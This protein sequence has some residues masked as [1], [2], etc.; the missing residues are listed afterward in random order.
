MRPVKPRHAALAA[1][2]A[3][4][5][6]HLVHISARSTPVTARIRSHAPGVNFLRSSQGEGKEV[7]DLSDHNASV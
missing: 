6:P 4:G 2:R 7:E 3:R 5:A 1:A